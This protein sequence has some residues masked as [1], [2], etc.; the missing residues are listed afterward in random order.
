MHILAVLIISDES[1]PESMMLDS[2]EGR[3]GF[4]DQPCMMNSIR[5]VIA[6]QAHLDFWA[7]VCHLIRLTAPGEGAKLWAVTVTNPTVQAFE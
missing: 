5:L 6:W 7:G 4:V 3:I 1:G 2:L